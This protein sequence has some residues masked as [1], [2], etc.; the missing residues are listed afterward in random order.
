MGK[1]SPGRWLGWSEINYES[2]EFTRSA[3]KLNIYLSLYLMES[4][5]SSSPICVLVGRQSS[6][7]GLGVCTGPALRKEVYTSLAL[8]QHPQS[9][10]DQAGCY[11]QRLKPGKILRVGSC[12]KAQK[13]WRLVMGKG[14]GQKLPTAKKSSRYSERWSYFPFLF[15]KLRIRILCL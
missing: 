12:G 9:L 6:V 14:I 1:K 7:K 3:Y 2:R 15:S 13:K 4:V 11:R 8:M 5:K 10:E